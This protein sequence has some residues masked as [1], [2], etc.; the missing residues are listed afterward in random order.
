[1]LEGTG[2]ALRHVKL[3]FAKDLRTPAV[4]GLLRAAWR[5]DREGT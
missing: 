2:K 3:R 4:K 5:L 1:V